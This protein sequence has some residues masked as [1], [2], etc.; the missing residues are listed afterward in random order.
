M[1]VSQQD[2]L[3]FAASFFQTPKVGKADQAVADHSRSVDSNDPNSFNKLLQADHSSTPQRV[4]APLRRTAPPVRSSSSDR[5]SDSSANA[6]A[7]D[8]CAAQNF[9]APVQNPAATS[10]NSSAASG[11]AQ[12]TGKDAQDAKSALDAQ[13]LPV[14]PRLLDPTELA[15]EAAAAAAVA[16]LSQ[17]AATEAANALAN[18]VSSATAGQQTLQFDSVTLASMSLDAASLLASRVNLASLA[19]AALGKNV[20]TAHSDVS[21][22]ATDG[23]T[24]PATVQPD[25]SQAA[26]QSSDTITVQI[27][28]ELLNAVAQGNR[29]QFLAENNQTALQALAGNDP[30]AASNQS[31]NSLGE[32]SLPVEL[33]LPVVTRLVVPVV[34]EVARPVQSIS[35]ALAQDLVKQAAAQNAATSQESAASNP[36]TQAQPAVALAAE[37]AALP[38]PSTSAENYAAARESALNTPDVPK[39]V[40]APVVTIAAAV[41]SDQSAGQ[42]GSGSSQSGSNDQSQGNHA[43]SQSDFRAL[44]AQSLAPKGAATPNSKD[45]TP[46]FVPDTNRGTLGAN[47][48][49]V[50]KDIITAQNSTGEGTVVVPSKEEVN[51]APVDHSQG[52]VSGLLAPAH[53]SRLADVSSKPTVLP[54][55]QVKAGD[56]WKTVQDAVQR[57]RSENPNHL[58]V[59]VRLEDGSSLGLELRMSS[60][61]LQA[62]FRSESQTLLKSIETQWNGFVTKESS[63]LKVVNAAFEGRSD[64]GA[65]NFSD[66]GTSGGER[67]QQMENAAAAASLGR[68]QRSSSSTTN[69]SGT[70]STATSNNL[71]EA[72]TASSSAQSVLEPLY[73]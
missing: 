29:E 19:A 8:S 7:S 9:S 37:N 53:A 30:Q 70:N 13:D 22:S 51:I 48:G 44:D 58:A 26:V 23:Q 54:P 14:D 56:V 5:S 15:L 28:P 24:Q 38:V 25:N 68:E 12:K 65:G 36:S 17:T 1:K 61:G 43:Q 60:A 72:A 67:R 21:A 4:D 47:E 20:P 52:D 31:L 41:V 2:Q 39:A 3:S 11:S 49:G 33:N 45:A 40:S 73:A 59:E 63:E 42:S 10:A 27:S 34:K 62:S 57:A 64:F 32:S 6:H 18:P 69:A 71:G 55:V 66:G 16:A 35:A 46:A 50:T